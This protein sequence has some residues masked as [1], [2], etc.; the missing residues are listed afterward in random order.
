MLRKKDEGGEE[1]SAV[2]HLYFTVEEEVNKEQL[3]RRNILSSFS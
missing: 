1:E 2:Y 3:Q